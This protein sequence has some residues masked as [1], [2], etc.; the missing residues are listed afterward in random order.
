MM[1]ISIS[2]S[3]SCTTTLQQQDAIKHSTHCYTSD[4]INII[5]RDE[6]VETKTELKEE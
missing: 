5:V 6:L 4:R 1:K 3:T 2:S